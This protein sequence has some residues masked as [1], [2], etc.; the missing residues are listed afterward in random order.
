MATR[1]TWDE[2]CA[3][4]ECKGRWVALRGCRYDERGQASE[5]D[6]V[7]L[8]EDLAQLCNRV[9]DG[10]LQDCAILFCSH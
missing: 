8:D 7:D 1:M 6:V 10:H 3:T 2:I 9:R 4:P 5:G